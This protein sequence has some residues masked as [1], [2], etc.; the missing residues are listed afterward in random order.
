MKLPQIMTHEDNVDYNHYINMIKLNPIACAVKLA[1][2]ED[3]MN[4]TEIK[5]VS[6]HELERTAKYWVAW[7]I[8]KGE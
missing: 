5:F 3:N 8:L 2:L 7:T 4:L 1:D 6:A